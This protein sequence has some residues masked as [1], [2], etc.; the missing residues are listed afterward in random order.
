MSS[1]QITKVRCYFL[2]D[3]FKSDL[4]CAGDSIA[5]QGPCQGDSGG[6]LMIEDT[7]TLVRFFK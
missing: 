3:L 2:T 1:F 6:P 7:G 4:M 5:Q